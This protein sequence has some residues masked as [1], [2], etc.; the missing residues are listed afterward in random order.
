MKQSLSQLSNDFPL[1][2]P[3]GLN[4]QIDQNQSNIDRLLSTIVTSKN[5]VVG[6]T[7]ALLEVEINELEKVVDTL[8]Q[9]GS[10]G[11]L[12]V[13]ER[14]LALEQQDLPQWSQKESDATKLIEESQK[15]QQ[16]LDAKKSLKKQLEFGQKL[17]KREAHLRKK[18][19]KLRH[20][21]EEK[22]GEMAKLEARINAFEQWL[23]DM[24]ENVGR[25]T[26]LAATASEKWHVHNMVKV[27][28][29]FKFG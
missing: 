13:V 5:A 21:V 19:T 7:L 15:Q 26:P 29:N 8:S 17:R 18:T 27:S 28:I 12:E 2:D 23:V 16:S 24:E 22:L 14:L 4:V 25:I 9:D 6:N 3:T 1:V 20:Q 10:T 11:Q